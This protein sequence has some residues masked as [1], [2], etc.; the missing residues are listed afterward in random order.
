MTVTSDALKTGNDLHE[1]RIYV[2]SACAD[3]RKQAL[4]EAVQACLRCQAPSGAA[5]DWYAGMTACVAAIR[6]LMEQDDD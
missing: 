5:T 2:M 1:L 6:V 4:E 3:A